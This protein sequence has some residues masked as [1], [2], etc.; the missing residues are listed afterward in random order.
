M[1]KYPSNAMLF[2][3]IKTINEVCVGHLKEYDC[4][5]DTYQQFLVRNPEHPIR[6]MLKKI[7]DNMEELKTKTR[8]TKKNEK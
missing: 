4:A 1:F 8:D 2:D 7:I 6:P 3:A 5:I